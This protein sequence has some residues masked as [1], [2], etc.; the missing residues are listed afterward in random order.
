MECGVCEY[1]YGVL[2]NWYMLCCEQQKP[3]LC[4]KCLS[5]GT[6]SGMVPAVVAGDPQQ[7]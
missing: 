2:E 1:R 5:G 3:I 7:N 6:I 4:L